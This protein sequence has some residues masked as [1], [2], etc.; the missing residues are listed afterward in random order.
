M[1]LMSELNIRY[2]PVLENDKLVGIISVKDLVDEQ[3]LEQ[4]SLIENLTNYISQ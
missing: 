1:K 3:I 4:K 2:L